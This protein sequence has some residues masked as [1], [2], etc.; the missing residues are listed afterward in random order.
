M[1]I[2][3]KLLKLNNEKLDAIDDDDD[4]NLTFGKLY[5]NFVDSNPV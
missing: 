1:N 5:E 4:F 3:V 2:N